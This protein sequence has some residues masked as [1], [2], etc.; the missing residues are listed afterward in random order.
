MCSLSA[1]NVLPLN[2]KVSAPSSR[3]LGRFQV[4]FE[5]QCAVMAAIM[6]PVC[7]WMVVL[8]NSLVQYKT[9]SAVFT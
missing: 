8:Q 3:N 1:G 7:E 5:E 4:H 2:I 9:D 6:V